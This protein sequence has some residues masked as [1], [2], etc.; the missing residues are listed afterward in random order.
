MQRLQNQTYPFG[1][2]MK[3]A[4]DLKNIISLR[5]SITFWAYL[6][7]RHKKNRKGNGF[8]VEWE[9]IKNWVIPS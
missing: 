5:F 1:P 8:G 9:G 2:I 4:K 6:L 3:L 7:I